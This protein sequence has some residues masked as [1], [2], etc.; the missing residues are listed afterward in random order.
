MP[1]TKFEVNLIWTWSSTCLITN[2]TGAGRFAITDTKLYV[3]AVTL[4]T[5]D[6]A[7][8]LKH[9]KSGFKRTVNWNKFYHFKMK[10][11]EQVTND[12]NFQL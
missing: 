12:I 1:L 8:L 6:N 10:H 5:Q 3:P 2:S 9:L 11:K 7:K 4:S